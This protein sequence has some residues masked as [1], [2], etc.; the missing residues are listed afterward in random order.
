[1]AGR[2]LV[3]ALALLLAAPAWARPQSSGSS[4]HPGGYHSTYAQYLAGIAQALGRQE[5]TEESAPSRAQG[6]RPVPQQQQQQ[7][8]LQQQ[9]QQQQQQ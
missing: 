9:Q 3:V 4:R 5:S 6:D 1:M 8:Q 2:Q 7:Q